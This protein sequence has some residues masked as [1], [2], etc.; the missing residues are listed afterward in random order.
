MS[1]L[2]SRTDV[3]ITE[4]VRPLCA[5]TRRPQMFDVGS[6]C[7]LESKYRASSLCGDAHL[8]GADFASFL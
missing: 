3:V 5:T 4:R 6:P 1:A 2:P 7:L 8:G